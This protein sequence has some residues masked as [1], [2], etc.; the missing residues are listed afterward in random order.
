VFTLASL[1]LRPGEGF[2]T[3]PSE[4]PQDRYQ[5]TAFPRAEETVIADLHEALRQ[6]MLQEAA[7]ELLR[8]QGAVSGVSAPRFSIGESDLAVSQ[9]VQ[10][11]VAQ[12]HAKD[13]RSQI[14]ERRHTAAHGLAVHHPILTPGLRRHP[15]EQVCSSQSVTELRPVEDGQRTHWQEEALSALEPALTLFSQ[16]TPGNQVMHVRMVAQVASPG[17]QHANH[18]DSPAHEAWIPGQLLGRRSTGAEDQIVDGFLIPPRNLPQPLR[19]GEGQQEVG[20][21]KPQLLL[22]VQPSL[23]FFSLALGTMPVLARV[24]AVLLPLTMRAKI[25]VPT[26]HIGPAAFN[27]PH[28][29]AVAGQHTRSVFL[30]VGWSLAAEDLRQLDHT[31]LSITRLMVSDASASPSQVRCV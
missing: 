23:R 13:V 9:S 15:L 22:P 24:V 2:R 25:H 21:R 7:D 30:P 18:A 31:S 11:P 29:P 20:N 5:Q 6:D 19:Q 17:V 28:R 8:P 1:C 26:Q 14:L 3:E 16:T 12:R 4:Q 27:I 10:A